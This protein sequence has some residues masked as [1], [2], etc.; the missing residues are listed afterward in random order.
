VVCVCDFSGDSA[1]LKLTRD[2]LNQ[3]DGSE[4]V[5]AQ[6]AQNSKRIINCTARIVPLLRDW[7]H[8][9]DWLGAHSTGGAARQT[10]VSQT[11]SCCS[12]VAQLASHSWSSA[13]LSLHHS[14]GSSCCNHS[15][16]PGSHQHV[17]NSIC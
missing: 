16:L 8:T 12:R 1:A 9:T 5:E 4:C 10:T 11:R 6:P 17:H 2:D 15:C 13:R 3:D 7:H 14:V